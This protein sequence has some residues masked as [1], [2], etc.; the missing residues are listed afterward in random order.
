[1]SSLSLFL[2]VTPEKGFADVTETLNEVRVTK[3][4]MQA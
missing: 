4:Y 2:A 3:R 1:M